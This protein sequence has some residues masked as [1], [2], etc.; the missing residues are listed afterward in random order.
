VP[1]EATPRALRDLGGNQDENAVPA[2]LLIAPGP[3]NARE[4]ECFSH[5]A[6]Q[7]VT[8]RDLVLVGPSRIAEPLNV[9]HDH[10]PVNGQPLTLYLTRFNE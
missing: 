2:I 10:G 3:C 1:A 7:A 9:D 8:N 4:A 5:R 6:V